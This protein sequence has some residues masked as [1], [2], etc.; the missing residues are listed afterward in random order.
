MDK[1]KYNSWIKLRQCQRYPVH[2][3]FMILNCNTQPE[4][5]SPTSS[6]SKSNNANIIRRQTIYSIPNQISISQIKLSSLSQM[7]SLHFFYRK[8]LQVWL[9]VD[10][11][12][13]F[14]QSLILSL[15]HK[16]EHKILTFLIHACTRNIQL[17]YALQPNL[18]FRKKKKSGQSTQNY[19]TSFVC[20]IV[21]LWNSVFF[22][23]NSS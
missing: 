2:W 18:P 19:I 20:E 3:K 21:S 14:I 5:K 10:P 15:P 12:H 4:T 7:H 16:D 1:L 13:T 8:H 22:Y 11:P 23:L 6:L 17:L 9:H